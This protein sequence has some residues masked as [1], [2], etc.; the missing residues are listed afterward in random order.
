MM[1]VQK[2]PDLDLEYSVTLSV[3]LVVVVLV[4][5]QSMLYSTVWEYFGLQT[6]YVDLE[7]TLNH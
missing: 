7:I 3:L 1:K 5:T 6:L 4:E 2:C